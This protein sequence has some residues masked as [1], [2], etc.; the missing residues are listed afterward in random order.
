MRRLGAA[1][2]DVGPRRAWKGEWSGTTPRA[3]IGG[4]DFDVR[5]LADPMPGCA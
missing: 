3:D 4:T 1:R 2:H 5:R